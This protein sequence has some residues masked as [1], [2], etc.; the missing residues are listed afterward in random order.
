M[1]LD[2]V[3]A[4]AHPEFA[5]NLVYSVTGVVNPMMGIFAEEFFPD[6]P[7][8]DYNKA[9]T[10]EYF[11]ELNKYWLTEFHLD[12]F[13]YD[14]VPGMFDGPTGNGYAFLTYETYQFSKGAIARFLT[15]RG[16]AASFNALSTCL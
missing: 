10:R 2:A 9:F 13:R 15:L 1:I 3:Y 7:G 8:T 16:T 4:H 12:G 14:Y 5:Y 6:R 11:L